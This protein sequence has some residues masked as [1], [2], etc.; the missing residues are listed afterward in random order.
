MLFI[1]FISQLDLKMSS[2]NKDK[3]VTTKDDFS[4]NVL[5]YQSAFQG[6]LA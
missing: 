2:K 5:G 3:F 1:S 4:G 6:I